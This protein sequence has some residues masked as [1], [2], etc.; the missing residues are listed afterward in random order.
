MRRSALH[1]QQEPENAKKRTMQS[2]RAELYFRQDSSDSR[3]RRG[4]FRGTLPEDLSLGFCF[5]SKKPD[6]LPN[7]Y[8]QQIELCTARR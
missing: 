1:E 8:P 7:S 3:P 5:S 6:L 2:E 4:A